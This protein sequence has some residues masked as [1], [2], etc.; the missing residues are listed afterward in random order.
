MDQNMRNKMLLSR[1]QSQGGSFGPSANP[2]EYASSLQSPWILMNSPEQLGA[3]T[4]EDMQ[5]IMLENAKN[6]RLGAL[7]SSDVALLTGGRR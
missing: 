5:R 4:Q 1:A 2:Q 6:Q 3:L 7:T